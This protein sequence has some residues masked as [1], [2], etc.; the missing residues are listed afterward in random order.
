[1]DAQERKKEENYPT[2]DKKITFLIDI[3][4]ELFFI[5]AFLLLDELYKTR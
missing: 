3:R 5:I 4:Y 2:N 1:M